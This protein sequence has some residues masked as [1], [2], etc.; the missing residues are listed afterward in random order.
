M[1]LYS[2][3]VSNLLSIWNALVYLIFSVPCFIHQSQLR[4]EVNTSELVVVILVEVFL[5]TKVSLGLDQL[6]GWSVEHNGSAARIMCGND[7]GNCTCTWYG[8]NC[9]IMKL[10]KV[11]VGVE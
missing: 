7:G 10:S 2:D 1:K 3:F 11:E 5:K 6:S 8:H 4:C 9:V